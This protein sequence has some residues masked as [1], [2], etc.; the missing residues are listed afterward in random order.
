MFQHRGMTNPEISDIP[1]QVLIGQA[2]K[3]LRETVRPRMTQDV[4]AE[5]M[6]VAQAT[7]YKYEKGLRDTLLDAVNQEK[8][9][10]ALGKSREDLLVSLKEVMAIHAS[11]SVERMLEPETDL[12]VSV[13]TAARIGK[14]GLGLYEAAEDIS[15][16]L[17]QHVGPNVRMTRIDTEDLMPLLHPGGWV[18]YDIKGIPRRHQPV[19]IRLK[20]GRFI[21]RLYS[22]SSASHVETIRMEAFRHGEKSAYSEEVDSIP[23][24]EVVGVY[25]ITLIGV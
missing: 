12:T 22:R 23:Y 9:A 14:E 5:N 18:L 8:A 2:L 17:G 24:T 6:G 20:T 21:P 11:G 4:A 10:R 25:P 15:Y 7:W 19:V 13:G 1:Q 16:D 3:K